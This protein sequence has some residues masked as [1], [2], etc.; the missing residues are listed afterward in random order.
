MK[1][2]KRSVARARKRAPEAEDFSSPR[3]RAESINLE[4]LGLIW[5]CESRKGIE[6]WD[7]VGGLSQ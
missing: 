2:C 5:I 4:I 6:F 1:Q 3:G 7:L